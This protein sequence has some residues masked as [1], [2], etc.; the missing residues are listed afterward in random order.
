MDDEDI[1]EAYRQRWEIELLWKFL[2]SH[3]KLDRLATKSVNGVT[4]QI[5]MVLIAYLILLMIGIPK[6]YYMYYMAR[7]C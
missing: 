2:K 4:I 1:R 6:I 7:N 3:F 5:Y